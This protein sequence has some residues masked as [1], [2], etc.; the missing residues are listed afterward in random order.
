MPYKSCLQ[1]IQ[2]HFLISFQSIII[3]SFVHLNHKTEWEKEMEKSECN[4]LTRIVNENYSFSTSFI[5]FRVELKQYKTFR[6][7][8]IIRWVQLHD[9]TTQLFIV[10]FIQ[11]YIQ[12]LWYRIGFLYLTSLKVLAFFS[13]PSLLS[14]F[15]LNSTILLFP[16][17]LN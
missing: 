14:C 11:H 12:F 8:N 3:K 5:L 17:I 1:V 15:F 9:C 10:V 16:S 7:H 6:Q 4:R 2:E 13:F